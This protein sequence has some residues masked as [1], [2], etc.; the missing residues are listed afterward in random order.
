MQDQGFN[1]TGSRFNS[2]F[3]AGSPIYAKQ[4]NDLATGVQA[5]LP[6]P[7]TGAGPS[8]SFTAGGAVIAG[9]WD[10]NTGGGGSRNCPFTIYNFHSTAGEE[11]TTY[12]INVY[13][14]TINNLVPKTEDGDLLTVDPPPEIQVLTTGFTT[15]AV[16]NYVYIKC[17]NVAPT[18]GD[19]GEYPVRDDGDAKY[20]TVVVTTTLQ[21]DDADNSYILLGTVTGQ[22]I[23]IPGTDPVEYR[24]D[25]KVQQLLGC[26]SLWTERFQCG[27][28]TPNYWWSSV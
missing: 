25:L 22:E 3:E 17:G 7:F 16:T 5:S 6:Q 12:Y 28:S 18:S 11:S 24:D 14:G 15:E 1:G 23:E 2:R 21:T 8:V 10:D 13:P 4:L 19:P 9:I 27:D 26:G 20:P